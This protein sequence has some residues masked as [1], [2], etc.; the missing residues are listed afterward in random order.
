MNTVSAKLRTWSA[1]CYEHG[2][3]STTNMIS[4]MLRTWSV[5]C[6]EHD[7]RNATNIVSAGVRCDAWLARMQIPKLELHLKSDG[8]SIYELPLFEHG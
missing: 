4:A 1:Q 5:Q 2:Q 8:N 6:Y 7:Q 3:Y